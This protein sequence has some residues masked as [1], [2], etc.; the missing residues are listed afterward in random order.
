M[1]YQDLKASLE[2]YDIVLSVVHSELRHHMDQE[3]NHCTNYNHT[4]VYLFAGDG[5]KV[6]II[7]ITQRDVG[8]AMDRIQSQ[9]RNVNDRRF[10]GILN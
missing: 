6:S 4:I 9:W 7:M 2:Y 8:S 5:Y 1:G 3:N 10:I